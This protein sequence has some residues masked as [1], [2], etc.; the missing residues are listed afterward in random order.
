MQQIA[1]LI[2]KCIHYFNND[3]L[4]SSNFN[5]KD[6]S[7][8]Y[9]AMITPKTMQLVLHQCVQKMVD[10]SIPK[11]TH[12]YAL[13]ITDGKSMYAHRFMAGQADFA[14]CMEYGTYDGQSIGDHVNGYHAFIQL[15]DIAC[16]NHSFDYVL[17][18]LASVHQCHFQRIV[19]QIASALKPGG[20]AMI[21][22]F[23]P[24]GK[25]RKSIQDHLKR[26]R[27]DIRCFEDYYQLCRE[28]NLRV[29]QIHEQFVDEQMRSCFPKEEISQYRQLKNTPFIVGI[30][31]FKPKK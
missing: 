2:E 15:P 22:D 28:N 8:S 30:S 21:V 6:E 3:P 20:Q 16:T 7:Q 23:H 10:E 17:A 9:G 4:Q 27:S 11:L 14:L 19:S 26:V 5:D 13:E 25:Y 29:M 31:V 12:K 1:A 18:K 24:F